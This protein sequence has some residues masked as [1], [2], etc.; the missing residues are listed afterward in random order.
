MQGFQG[1]AA[2]AEFVANRLPAL[3][4]YAFVLTGQRQDAEE[5]GRVA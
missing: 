3:Y 2:F 1:D 4:R 5:L